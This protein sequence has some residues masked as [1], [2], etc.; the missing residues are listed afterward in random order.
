MHISTNDL[1]CCKSA[2]LLQLAP[3]GG[4]PRRRP[5]ATAPP[6][7]SPTMTDCARRLMTGRQQTAPAQQHHSKDATA[8]PHQP[9]AR[10]EP[11][12]PD[13]AH[14]RRHHP[15]SGN[16]CGTKNCAGPCTGGGGRGRVWEGPW[17]LYKGPQRPPASQISSPTAARARVQP[18]IGLFPLDACLRPLRTS[19]K[20]AV[21][22]HA[23][24]RCQHACS[25]SQHEILQKSH[26]M[27]EISQ[28]QVDR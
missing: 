3:S 8:H 26:V 11:P 24:Y 22:Q 7:T 15:N 21:F 5:L 20:G 18:Y 16:G 4:R 13:P 25:S 28:A 19:G 14:S 10:P 27:S 6:R 23:C 2:R 1:Q 9:G 12:H 17:G